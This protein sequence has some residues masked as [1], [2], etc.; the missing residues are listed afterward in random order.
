MYSAE[1]IQQIREQN[2]LVQR[3]AATAQSFTELATSSYDA[4]Q[5]R[6]HALSDTML[7]ELQKVQVSST[8]FAFSLTVQVLETQRL[9]ASFHR[10]TGFDG[11]TPRRRASIPSRPFLS[12]LLSY[13]R[14]QCAPNIPRTHPGK[15]QQ[16][17]RH[18]RGARPPAARGCHLARA[19][20]AQHSLPTERDH[21]S[22]GAAKRNSDR[23][24][25]VCP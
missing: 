12:P 23:W 6:V 13:H 15:I 7:V 16:G 1:Q 19:R 10:V 18:H 4:A 14:A 17:P 21:R 8:F 5:V 2:A 3:A 9:N 11:R 25:D 20:H 24:H 22:Q